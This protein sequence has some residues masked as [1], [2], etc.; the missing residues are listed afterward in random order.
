[1]DD[2]NPKFL[3]EFPNVITILED[4]LY[5]YEGAEHKHEGMGS[6]G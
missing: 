1:M 3:S 6:T 5:V 2:T 4:N